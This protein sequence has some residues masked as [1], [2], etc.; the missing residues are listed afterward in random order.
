[1]LLSSATSDHILFSY[2]APDTRGDII[3]GWKIVLSLFSSQ[4]TFRVTTGAFV[5]SS[6]AF[7]FLQQPGHFATPSGDGKKSNEVNYK[8]LKGQGLLVFKQSKT[9]PRHF[10]SGPSSANLQPLCLTSTQHSHYGSVY[11]V[12]SCFSQFDTPFAPS[13]LLWCFQTLRHP[14]KLPGSWLM[15]KT[16]FTWET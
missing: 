4:E 1:M 10:D 3:Q 14:R 11:L 9:R 16:Q 7:C 2:C 15:L 6:L 8:S 13:F 12:T 5:G